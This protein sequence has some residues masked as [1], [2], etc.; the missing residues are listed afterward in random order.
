MADMGE[1]QRSSGQCRIFGQNAEPFVT[2][3]GFSSSTW[4]ETFGRF[5]VL[6]YEFIWFYTMGYKP[7]MTGNHTKNTT[8]EHLL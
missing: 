5:E 4:P 3:R 2:S 6:S 7:Y 1:H 8:N